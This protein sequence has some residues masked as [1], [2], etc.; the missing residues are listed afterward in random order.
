M[1][2]DDSNDGLGRRPARLIRSNWENTGKRKEKKTRC[3]ARKSSYRIHNCPWNVT[4]TTSKFTITI[5]RS[6]KNRYAA[7]G[8]RS[9][10][11]QAEGETT[12]SATGRTRSFERARTH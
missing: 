6:R 8:R 12:G 10:T 5:A 1:A 2:M 11:R 9:G 3:H 4:G 7:I